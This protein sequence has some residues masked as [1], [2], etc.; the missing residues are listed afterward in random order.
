M[1]FA[2]VA[3]RTVVVVGPVLVAPGV[4]VVGQVRAGKLAGP[5]VGKAV[6]A[7]PGVGAAVMVMAPCA[8]VRGAA[9]DTEGFEMIPHQVL[10]LG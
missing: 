5:G 1:G 7:V 2:A 4:E 8:V 6:V 9:I 10:V 3:V